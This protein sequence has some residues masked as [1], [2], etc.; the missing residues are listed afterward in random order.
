M[1]FWLGGEF[2]LMVL[3]I[4]KLEMVFFEVLSAADTNLGG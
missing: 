1:W 3:L 2:C 4:L